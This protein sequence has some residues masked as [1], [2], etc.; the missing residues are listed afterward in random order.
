MAPC[1]G[2][3]RGAPSEA[4]LAAGV[5][6]ARN[7]IPCERD[8]ANPTYAVDMDGHHICRQCRSE[9]VAK[10]LADRIAKNEVGLRDWSLNGPL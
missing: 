10:E 8:H 9:D 2:S 6:A 7:L 3:E 4:E 1:P 5:D